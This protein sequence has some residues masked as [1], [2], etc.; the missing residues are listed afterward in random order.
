MISQQIQT[1][2]APPNLEESCQKT[3]N[4]LNSGFQSMDDLDELESL[5]LKAK[6]HNDELRANVRVNKPGVPH[7]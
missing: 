1:L 3:T 6:A 7:L 5:V 2:L 4:F